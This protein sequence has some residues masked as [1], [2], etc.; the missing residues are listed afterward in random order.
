[1]STIRCLANSAME[2]THPDNAEIK[3]AT[4]IG[5][6]ELPAWVKNDDYFKMGIVAGQ[7]KPFEGSSDKTIEETNADMV[8]AAEL[9]DEIKALEEKLDGVQLSGNDKVKALKQEIADLE[10]ARD[11]AKAGSGNNKK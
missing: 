10:A 3:A 1:M 11:A 9:K 7:I 2:F 5:F 6:C 8:K 4:K